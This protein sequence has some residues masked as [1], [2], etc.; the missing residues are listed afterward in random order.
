MVRYF[1]STAPAWVHPFGNPSE[2]CLSFPH[3]NS[4]QSDFSGLH[5]SFEIVIII[6]KI[7]SIIITNNK[8]KMGGGRGIKDK[9]S[10]YLSLYSS[11]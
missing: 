1:A 7:I 3:Q 9:V 10:V 11:E 8:A 6:N 4:G 2:K 5:D